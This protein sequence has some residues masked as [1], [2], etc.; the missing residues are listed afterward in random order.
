MKKLFF[1][2]TLFITLQARSQDVV[3]YWYGIASLSNGSPDTYL[4]ELILKQNSTAVQGV[5]NYYFRNTFRS[6]KIQGDYN[7]SRRQL[8]LYNIPVPFPSA[9]T[10]MEVDCQMDFVALHRVAKAGSNLSGRFLAKEGYRY[11]C[12]EIIFDLRLNEDAGNQD[13][14]LL[15]LRNFK[16]TFQVWTPSGSDTLVAATVHQRTIENMVVSREYKERENIVEQEIEVYSDSLQIDVFDNGEVDGDSISVFFND[17]L[18]GANL[19]LSTRAIHMD[20]V[21]DNTREINTVSMFANNLGSIPPNTALM[22][23]FDGRRRHEIRLS[24]TLQK[25]GTVRI[26]RIR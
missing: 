1:L 14:V 12:P 24:S 25:N 6:T 18:L 23:V 5:L 10:N 2:L 11:M 4:V 16:E 22:V 8:S 17:K 21:L 7:S 15:A 19:N 9:P 3:G 20:L 26:R 13:S